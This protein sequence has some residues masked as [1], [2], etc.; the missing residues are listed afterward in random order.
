[1][2]LQGE[3]IEIIY[4]NELNSYCIA[5]FKID[6]NNVNSDEIKSLDD[7]TTIVGYLP[8]VNIGDTLKVIGKITEHQEYGKQ[9]K[10]DT[11]E[12]M[13]PQTTK[14][15]ERYLANC[16]IKGIGPATAKKIVDTF[17]ED[18]LNV[19]KFEPNKLSQIKGIT[20]ERASEI[21]N[22][23]IENWEVWQL[24]G[25]LDKFGIGPQSAEKIYKMLGINA[26][27]EIESNPYILI[28]LVNKVNFEQIDK[29]ALGLGIDH[30]NEKRIR[31]GIKHALML[32]T[33]NGHCCTRYDS[34]IDFVVKLLNVSE[35]DVEN[36]IINMKAKEDIVLEERNEEEW[37]YLYS[38][39]KSEENI[40]RRLIDLDAY[41]KVKK[42]DKFEEEL[43]IFE[44]KSNIDLSEKQREAI[45]AIN[46]NN[47]CV[48][49][50]RTRYW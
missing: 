45:E 9:I 28:D 6:K 14:A 47:V 13:M 35:N 7:E 29:M 30:N 32:M 23:F 41:K 17:G 15:L 49:T 43:K 44:E 39:Y 27:E 4:K 12:K 24:V 10:V 42:I 5:V 1:M 34:L 8:F 25:F 33:Y 48:I 31:S 3:V 11:F 46:D 16:G 40:A 21:A 20:N 36:S 22:T 38:Y 18:T 2:E 37:V 50:G 19:F 26:I